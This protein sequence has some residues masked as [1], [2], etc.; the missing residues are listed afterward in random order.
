[1]LPI[2]FDPLRDLTTLQREFDDML[3]RMFGQGRETPEGL[4]TAAPTINCY[5]KDNVYHLEADLPG[6]DVENL[7]VRIDGS[8]LTIHG[9]RRT[10]K[11]SDETDYM[12]RESRVTSFERRVRLPEG[13]D[14]DKAHASFKDGMLEVT[15]PIA[16]Q[17][18][19]GRKIPVERF[20]S[21]KKSKEIH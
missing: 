2:R 6:V 18:E 12:L 5:V 1:M 4:L 20:K 17:L 21:E 9:E 3:R 10:G 11:E 8:E 15:M 7:D 16:S 19:T 14:G 13:A